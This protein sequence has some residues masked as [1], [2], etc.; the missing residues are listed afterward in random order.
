MK[1]LRRA[2]PPGISLDRSRTRPA[3]SRVAAPRLLVQALFQP[4]LWRCPIL[5]IAQ[6][7]SCYSGCVERNAQKD[8]AQLARPLA[9]AS[10]EELAAQQGAIP[11]EDIEALM[12]RPSAEDESAE[13]FSAML[14]VWRREGIET[15]APE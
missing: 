7:Q 6:P 9:P 15:P 12:G 1:D 13:E 8:S 10:F 4:A 14:R 3:C 5:R 11:V 2:K